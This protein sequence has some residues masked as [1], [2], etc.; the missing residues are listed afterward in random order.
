MNKFLL[1][2]V[3]V[4]VIS[5]AS[6][7]SDSKGGGGGSVVACYTLEGELKSVEL[8]DIYEAKAKGMTLQELTGDFE[9]D[10]KNIT[11]KLYKKFNFHGDIFFNKLK[12]VHSSYRAI[13]RDA[14]LEVIQDAWPIFLP[15]GCKIKQA[16]NY[17]NHMNIWL[18][19]NLYEKMDYQNQFALAVHEVI[20]ADDRENGVPDSR[21][22]RMITST[23][24]SVND[25]FEPSVMQGEGYYCSTLDGKTQFKATQYE[26][27]DSNKFRFDFYTVNGHKVYSKKY[28]DV[29]IGNSPL[30]KN[31]TDGRDVTYT[32]MN[33][34]SQINGGELIQIEASLEGL[35]I[36]WKG[37]D[38]GD[39][40]DYKSL[41]CT[42]IFV[43]EYKH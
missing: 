6:I 21:Y 7:K 20:Y 8:L 5:W 38:P 34:K 41:N 22:T 43:P 11:A 19:L 30:S 14:E 9:Q 23:L 18:D 13:P 12:G 29:E 15:K 4:P 25:P 31:D 26:V 17:Y 42:Y 28:A 1:A 3:M 27:K 36:A 40:H 35:R 39:S 33:L 37:S 32:M 24:L 16:V 2:L 10:A